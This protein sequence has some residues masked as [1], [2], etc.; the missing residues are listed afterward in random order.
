MRKLAIDIETFSSQDLPEVG[1]Y[2]YAEA[3]DFQV[4]IFGYAFDDDPV[5]VIDCT[6]YL[7]L[8]LAL[9]PEV[10][11]AIQNPDVLK[12]A[13]NAAFERTCLASALCREMPPE[14]WSCTAVMAA[15][16]GLPRSLSGVGTALG[17]PEDL[18]KAKTGKA[19]IEYFSKP[20][21]PTKVNGQRTRNLPEHNPEK[22]AEYMEY[23]RQDVVAE[24]EIRKKLEPHSIDPFE[25]ILWVHDQ[26]IND[27]GARVDQ[28]FVRAAMAMGET[29]KAALLEEA[30]QLTGLENPNSNAQV[31]RWIE[32]QTG[33]AV[34]SLNKE[35]VIELRKVVDNEAV[36]KLLTLRSGLS[37][38]SNA[39]YD[40]IA[41]TVCEDG[42]IRGTARFYGAGKTGRWA[43]Q[44]PQLQ[45]LP[46]NTIDDG[47]LDAARRI[48][49]LG[50]YETMGAVF[51]DVPGTLSQLIRTTL[52]S[53]PGYRF[54]VAD[55]S[56][57]EARVIA[58]MAGEQ[59]R[60]EVF[61]THGK[62]YEASAEQMFHL[63]P[64]SVGK[65][66]PMRQKGKIAELALGYGGS[67]GALINMGALRMGLTEPELL[68][69]VKAWRIANPNIVQ[70]W[71]AADK[72]MR[73]TIRTGQTQKLDLVQFRKEGPILR[74][75]LPSGRELSYVKPSVVDDQITYA[76]QDQATQKW[77]RV[78]SYGP[79]IVENII[80]ATARDCLAVAIH[81]LETRGFKIVFHVHDEVICEVRN[82]RSSADEISEIMSEPID[83][84]QGLP[85]RA[86]AYE[87]EYYRKA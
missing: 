78:E 74:L 27:R 61:H 19:L 2:R 81:R 33:V 21:R 63:Q 20:C 8:E 12:T 38:T 53:E 17:L 5:T 58:W 52:I 3:D 54:I 41:E 18:Q 26:R 39:K 9:P 57:I 43:G 67:I 64:G 83:W 29:A 66:N 15:E 73:Y 87:C 35:A 60:M 42:R 59:W 82:G 11:A 68:P 55:F 84:A 14:Q 23:N 50:D 36:Q 86:D 49:K 7:E 13:F 48:V 34:P 24:R 56:A 6:R 79:K 28:V 16:L 25:Q 70:Y 22:W 75:R 77:G 62:I 1:V 85:L 37:R 80:Q 51:D 76:G 72:A 10:R 44:G 47:S 65:D 71:W 40:K 45:N 69:L 30:R 31:K 46:R 4:L 32:E